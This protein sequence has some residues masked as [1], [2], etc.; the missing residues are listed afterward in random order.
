AEQM[1]TSLQANLEQTKK[2]VFDP[3]EKMKGIPFVD[4]ISKLERIMRGK[5]NELYVAIAMP[6]VKSIG[7]KALQFSEVKRMTN[8]A[9][10]VHKLR[11]LEQADYISGLQKEFPLL[12]SNPKLKNYLEAQQKEISQLTSDELLDQV[13]KWIYSKEIDLIRTENS[14]IQWT[15]V[16]RTQ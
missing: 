11:A 15:E 12:F 1:R 5:F 13:H 4:R 3:P 10:L 6:N 9:M 2:F 7:L 16:K 14:K 8:A